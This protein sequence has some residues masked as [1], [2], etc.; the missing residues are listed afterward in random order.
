MA[1]LLTLGL[2]LL[3]SV[4]AAA[5]P[6]M[7]DCPDSLRSKEVPTERLKNGWKFVPDT[8]PRFF[9]NIGLYDGHPSQRVSLKPDEEPEHPFWMAIWLFPKG[10]KNNWIG[11]YFRGS[12]SLLAVKLPDGFLRCTAGYR[13]RGSEIEATGHVVCDDGTPP[14]DVGTLSH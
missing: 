5:E 1:R 6:M 13:R 2:I 14:R 4:P 9:Q 3:F 7:F 11:C 12:T 10:T 8:S